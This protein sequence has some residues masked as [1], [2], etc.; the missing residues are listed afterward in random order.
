MATLY[1]NKLAAPVFAQAGAFVA[2]LVVGVLT[3]H[4]GGKPAPS[5]STSTS[6]QPRISV[7]SHGPTSPGP[8]PHGPTS[9]GG[10]TELTIVIQGSSD[11]GQALPTVTAE[12]FEDHSARPLITASLSQSAALSETKVISVPAGHTYQVCVRPPKNFTVTATSPNTD[13]VRGWYCLSEEAGSTAT[14]DLAP[15]VPN[16]GFSNPGFPNPGTGA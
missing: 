2:V 14:F 5:S 3:G 16:P 13:A 8:T 7:T 12:V 1:R 15:T 4:G 11:F 6:P 10:N 9:T